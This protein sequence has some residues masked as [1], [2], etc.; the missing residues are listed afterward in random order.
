MGLGHKGE[1]KS[2]DLNDS[3]FI[4]GFATIS[5]AQWDEKFW[6]SNQELQLRE[7]PTL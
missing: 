5:R 2:R 3:E 1:F 6:H 4:R 7:G